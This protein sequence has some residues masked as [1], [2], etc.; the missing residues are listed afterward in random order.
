MTDRCPGGWFGRHK[1][2][3][4]Y[5]ILPAREVTP[6]QIDAINRAVIFSDDTVEAIGLLATG[7]K[8]YV[9]DICMHCGLT[10][11]PVG[12]SGQ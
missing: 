10:F 9:H 2:Q 8:K 1:L 4:R 6:Q 5:E 3:A 11:H 7:G 12:G